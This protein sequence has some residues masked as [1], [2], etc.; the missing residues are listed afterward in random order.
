M[1]GPGQPLLRPDAGYDPEP[2]DAER[3]DRVEPGEL[4]SVVYRH[5]DQDA[6][7]STW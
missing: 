7:V 6:P 4:A 5:R 3:L 1:G 2:T